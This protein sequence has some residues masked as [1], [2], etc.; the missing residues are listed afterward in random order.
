MNS[1][2]QKIT[3]PECGIWREGWFYLEKD[4]S[5]CRKGN[6][7]Q[8]LRMYY[9]GT[10]EESEMIGWLRHKD[11]TLVK[12]ENCIEYLY[13]LEKGVKPSDTKKKAVKKVV[14]KDQKVYT[15]LIW[16]E[17]H[18][19][20]DPD[21]VLTAKSFPELMKKVHKAMDDLIDENEFDEVK[22]LFSEEKIINSEWPKLDEIYRIF[23]KESDI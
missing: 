21:V 1:R 2:K 15:L 22:D 11:D 13:D 10:E 7:G 6:H 8:N 16:S 20:E 19:R 12:C 23:Y 4:E 5:I 17:E 3:C 9:I 14:K 18:Y